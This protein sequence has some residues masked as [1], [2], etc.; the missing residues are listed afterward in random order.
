MSKTLAYS[1]ASQGWTSFFS[2]KPEKM[3]GMNSYFYSFKNGNLWRHNT[4]E[5]RNNFY[6]EQFTSK[7]V[8][9]FNVDPNAVK[10]FN[11]FVTN[12]DNPWNCTFYTDLS[13]GYI[14]SS[15]FVEKEG[16]YFAHIR[17]SS[18]SNDLKLRS[19]QGIGVPLH[20]ESTN[21]TAVVVTF[22]RDIGSI[23]STGDTIMYGTITSGA[24][25]SIQ[26]AGLVVSRTSKSI[27]IDTT[28]GSIP[29]VTDM[30]LYMK[31]MSVESYGLRGYYMQFELENTATSRV[32]LYNVQ[33]SIFKSNP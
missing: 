25:S 22:G 27:T 14:L 26:K 28:G 23:I 16:G 13:K 31:D 2:Y 10:N 5:K 21:P 29:L 6:D 33:S 8:G 12:D 19:S 32:Q 3:I 20:M 1:D 7:V 4:N 15:Q 18:N 17:S 24:V 9:V 11:T 30:F